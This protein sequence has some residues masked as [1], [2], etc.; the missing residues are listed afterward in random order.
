MGVLVVAKLA[1]VALTSF[2]A[3]TALSPRDMGVRAELTNGK[4]FHATRTQA[5]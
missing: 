2:L 5:I 4:Y 1:S 3:L